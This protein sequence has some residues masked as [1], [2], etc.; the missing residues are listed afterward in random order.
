MLSAH[1]YGS[2]DSQS[3]IAKLE[4][5]AGTTPGSDDILKAFTVHNTA[6]GSTSISLDGPLQEGE[7]VF[8]T[9]RVWNRAGEADV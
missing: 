5:F 9:I 3:G 7:Q 6:A 4:L 2:H 1:W 8:W